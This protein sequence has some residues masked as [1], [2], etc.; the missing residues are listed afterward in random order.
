MNENNLKKCH[1]FTF[2]LSML[3]VAEFK[4]LSKFLSCC[5]IDFKS[6]LKRQCSSSSSYGPGTAQHFA[7]MFAIGV[8]I[9]QIT[10][11]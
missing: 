2:S 5:S 11:T 3:V 7:I 10:F 1:R 4:M 8:Q 9:N 6:V